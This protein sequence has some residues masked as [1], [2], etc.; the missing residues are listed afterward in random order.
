MSGGLDT[1]ARQDGADLLPVRVPV[2]ERLRDDHA[3]SDLQGP[4]VDDDHAFRVD[5]LGQ[6]PLPRL[7]GP[8]STGRELTE[9]PGP[10]A[11]HQAIRSER[12]PVQSQRLLRR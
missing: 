7:P 4:V 1:L 8:L 11:V 10:L 9:N 5:R 6:E 2:V 12:T 3:G